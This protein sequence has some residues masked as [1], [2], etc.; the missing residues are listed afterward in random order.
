MSK[1]CTHVKIDL[2]RKQGRW[3]MCNI[4]K[5]VKTPKM[6]NFNPTY[7]SEH[8]K[9]PPDLDVIYQR[10]LPIWT[11]L[12]QLS[13]KTTKNTI[14]TLKTPYYTKTTTSNPIKLFRLKYIQILNI[15]YITTYYYQLL[16]LL[17]ILVIIFTIYLIIIV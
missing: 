12:A 5:T 15:T 4:S 9:L 7:K 6:T 16:L 13:G 10:I 1:T 11:I 8:L 3:V 14:F 17:L 2:F